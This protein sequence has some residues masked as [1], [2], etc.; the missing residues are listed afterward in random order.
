MTK[1]AVKTSVD[2]TLPSSIVTK[3]DLSRVVTELEN[4]DN[5]MTTALVRAE[6]GGPAVAAPVL[7][8][9]LTDFL[10]QNEL[11]LDNAGDRSDLIKNLRKLKDAVPVIHMTFAVTA[12]PESLQQLVHWLRTEVDARAVIE[13]GLQPSLIAG[14]YVRT[15]NHVHDLSL[16]QML[17][18]SRGMLV[19]ELGALRGK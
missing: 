10:N 11:K 12:D 6:K 14:V 3:I 2:F 9:Q 13:V 8:Q 15:P 4:V 1:E 17:R 18:S 19:E 16:R 7:S 5:T